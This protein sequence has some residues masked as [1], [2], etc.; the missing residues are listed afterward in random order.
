MTFPPHPRRPRARDPRRPRASGCPRRCRRQGELRRR[1]E[2]PDRHRKGHLRPRLSLSGQDPERFRRLCGQRLVHGGRQG[3]RQRRRDR[4]GFAR[5]P[6][7]QRHRP[8]V[9]DRRFRH[10]DRRLGRVLGHLDRR[11]PLVSCWNNS[12]FRGPGF[13]RA[14]IRTSPFVAHD[15]GPKTGSH[16]SGPCA[17]THTKQSQHPAETDL[18]YTG[19]K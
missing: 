4:H 15:L 3:R 5:Q 6:E 12:I 17:A 13:G 14:S 19:H 11:A 18:R 2:R 10:L 7:R 1:L 16:F 9:G 8:H